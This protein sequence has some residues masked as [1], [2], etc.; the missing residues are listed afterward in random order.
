MNYSQEIKIRDIIRYRGELYSVVR[1]R[2]PLRM[3]R[4]IKPH[5]NRHGKW[6]KMCDIEFVARPILGFL[7]GWEPEVKIWKKKM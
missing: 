2:I 7:E 5:D 4:V 6:V 3:L 1:I